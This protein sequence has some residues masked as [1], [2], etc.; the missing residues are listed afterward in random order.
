MRFS[1]R[2]PSWRRGLGETIACRFTGT[3]GRMG[4]GRVLLWRRRPDVVCLQELKATP[5]RVPELVCTLPGYWCYWHG[6][7][8]YSVALHL[9]KERFPEAPHVMTHWAADLHTRGRRVV[10]CSDINIAREERDVHPKERQ[11]N[12]IGQRREERAAFAWLLAQGLVD[13][14]RAVDPDNDALFPHRPNGPLVR[15]PVGVRDERPWTGPRHVRTCLSQP[16]PRCRWSSPRT[17]PRGD[18]RGRRMRRFMLTMPRQVR[19]WRSKRSPHV[20]DS[21]RAEDP[22]PWA[23]VPAVLLE[24]VGRR[25]RARLRSRRFRAEGD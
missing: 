22:I 16:A 15:R 9:R 6:A 25:E 8:A 7:R 19:G 14:G 2:R 12:L 13:V 21:N 10:L 4:S 23:H 5:E 20:K 1:S 3:R 11:P 18:P 24:A 17:A